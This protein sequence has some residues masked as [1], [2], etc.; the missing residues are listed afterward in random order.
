LAIAVSLFDR[1]RLPH[2]HAKAL[3]ALGAALRDLRRRDEAADAFNAAAEVFASL[4]E[5]VEQ[6]AALFNLGLVQR[7]QGE[8]EQA[9]QSFRRA[10]ER[11]EAQRAPA[12]RELGSLLLERGK[13]DEATAV[14]EEALALPD[15]PRARGATANAL[16]LTHL[17]AGRADAAVAAFAEAAGAYGR[18]LRPANYAMAKANIA[19]AF[20]QAGQLA[21]A[22]LAARQALRVDDAAQAVRAQAEAVLA[23]LGAVTDDLI[24]VLTNETPERQQTLLREE[25]PFWDQSNAAAFVAADLTPDALEAWLAA[26]LELP[27][28]EFESAIAAT[29]RVLGEHPPEERA[30]FEATLRA[31]LPRFHDPQMRRLEAAFGWDTPAI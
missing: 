9:A 3:N 15:D 4:Q 26:L 1:D 21:D 18:S 27:P 10:A 23:R 6:G 31:A 24:V 14:L 7:D 30:Q 2:E 22:R 11:L 19:L 28:D 29:R 12:L 25:V 5:P 13:L 17:A 8:H 20:E 16:G